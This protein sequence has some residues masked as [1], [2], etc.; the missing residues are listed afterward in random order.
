MCGRYALTRALEELARR[1]DVLLPDEPLLDFAPRYNLAPAEFAVVVVEKEGRRRFERMRWGLVPSWAKDAAAGFKCINARSETIAEKPA[2]R[3]PF[4]RTR[5]LV[6]A[7]SFYE[8]PRPRRRG[9]PP[10]RARLQDGGTFAMAGVWDEWRGGA[11]P[12]RSF[13]IVTVAAAPPLAALHDRMPAILS[14]EDEALW[15]DGSAHSERLLAALRPSTLTL[16]PASSRLNK[17]GDDGP[18]CWQADPAVADTP[19]FL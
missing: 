1:F 12:L 17:P 13:S 16:A 4:A 6:A 11:T 2:F 10:V 19:S 3:G 14:R 9:Q 18:E 5:C 15:L 7:D 8:W